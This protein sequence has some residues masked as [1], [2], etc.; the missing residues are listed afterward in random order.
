MKIDKRRRPIRHGT[1][2]GYIGRHCRCAICTAMMKEYGRRYRQERP[3]VG[4]A[5]G[6]LWETKNKEWHAF[7]QQLRKRGLTLDQF[8]ALMERQDFS[9]AICGEALDFRPT[10]DHCHA[11]NR[12]RGL[13]CMNCNL[14][15]GHFGDHP[16]RLVSAAQYLERR[17]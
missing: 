5:A 11:T 10:V 16:A 12:V 7:T 14:G 15:L 6:R 13:L 17:S 1:L 3:D 9:C 2:H 8:H 4:R